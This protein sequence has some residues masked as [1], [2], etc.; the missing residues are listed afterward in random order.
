MKPTV[1]D[2]DSIGYT[3]ITGGS[4]TSFATGLAAIDAAEDV[5]NQM[6]ARAA[7]IWDTSEDDVEY[8]NGGVY[9]KSDEELKFSLKTWPDSWPP[10]AAPSLAVPMWTPRG[11]ATDTLCISQT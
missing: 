5:K 4:R 3:F 10:P 2:T 7:K 9:H 11:R 1:V 6:I 8:V